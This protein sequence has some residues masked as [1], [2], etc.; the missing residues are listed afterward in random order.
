MRLGLFMMPLHGPGRDLTALLRE[1]QEAILLAE[2]LGF[3][4]AWVGEHLTASTE[5]I[6]SPLIFLATLIAQ[7]RK[8]LLGTGVM[9]LPHHHPAV[10]AGHCALFDHLSGGRLLLGIGPGGLPSD[11]ELFGLLGRDDRGERMIEAIDMILQIWQGEPPWRIAGRFW[12]FAVEQSVQPGLGIGPMLKPLQRPHPPIAI[13]VLGPNAGLAQLAGTRGWS[14]ISANFVPPAVIA[15][16]WPLYAKGCAAAG[17]PA[18]PAQWRVAR[19]VLVTDDDAQA[20]DYLA[21]PGTGLR[22]YYRYL[23]DQLSAAGQS[24]VFKTDPALPDAALTDDYLLE[25]MVIAGSPATVARRL[26][27]LHHDIGPFGTLLIAAHEWD[28]PDM[29]RR[30]MELLAGDVRARLAWNE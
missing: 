21:R 26:D 12:Q 20:R 24:R 9:A 15:T 8:I 17:R 18:D 28:H 4:E 5:P 1:D 30:S 16:H 3:D 6:A 25:T 27:Q 7:T 11:I 2:R 29:W 14:P 23:C 13:S 10:V 19:S 22:F